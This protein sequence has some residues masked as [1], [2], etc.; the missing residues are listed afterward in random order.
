MRIFKILIIGFLFG[1]QNLF[2]Q[3]SIT[4]TPASGCDTVNVQFGLAP[5][6][7]V[8][9]IATIVWD[10]GNGETLSGNSAP[11]MDYTIPGFYAVNCLINNNTNLMLPGFIEVRKGPLASFTTNDT[12]LPDPFIKVFHVF[13]QPVQTNT[14]T[15]TW[16]FSDG[17]IY[18]GTSFIHTFPGSGFYTLNLSVIDQ[19]GCTDEFEGPIVVGNIIE[20]PNVFSPNGDDINDYMRVVTNGINVFSLEIYSR[21]G[22]L[23]YKSESSYLIWDGRSMSGQEMSQGVYYYVIKQMDG[24]SGIEKKGFVHLLR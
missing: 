19:N 24:F 14:Y 5:A 12:L 4:A 17:N 18:S 8:D 16:E 6:A 23:V 3:L 11:T 2:A 10:F 15:Y 21:S 7:G 13:P 22:L 1:G 9:T 20:V